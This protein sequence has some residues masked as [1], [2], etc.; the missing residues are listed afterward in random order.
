MGKRRSPC[1]QHRGHADAGAEVLRIGSDGDQRLAGGLE[2]DVIDHRL[3]VIRHLSDRRGDGEHDMIVGRRQELVLA[4][5]K[6][7]LGGRALALGA[8]AV[9]A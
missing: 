4:G 3:V 9:A 6:Q 7:V 8:M 2:Q 5:G 1:V